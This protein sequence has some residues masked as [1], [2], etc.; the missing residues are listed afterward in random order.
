MGSL[1]TP[2]RDEDPQSPCTNPENSTG[3]G[4]YGGLLHTIHS[5]RWKP[6][7]LWPCSS[8]NAGKLP[9][10]LHALR[11]AMNGHR[12]GSGNRYRGVIKK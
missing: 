9:Y 8:V 4:A 6:S 1:L 11:R 10:S 5:L 2:N 7:I 3:T 12:D